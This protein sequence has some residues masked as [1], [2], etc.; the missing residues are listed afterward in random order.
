VEEEE[1]EGRE[2]EVEGR[3]EEEGGVED[4]GKE[5]VKGERMEEKARQ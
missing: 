5:G 2:E 4:E 1:V 3:E